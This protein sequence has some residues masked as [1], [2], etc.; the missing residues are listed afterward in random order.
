MGNYVNDLSIY[1][2]MNKNAFINYDSDKLSFYKNKIKSKVVFFERL[3]E[4]E[5]S[6]YES[7]SY[8]YMNEDPKDKRA[9]CM[10]E[11]VSIIS[12][13]M[14]ENMSG[15]KYREISENENK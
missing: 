12:N 11:I 14:F 9:Y 3:T 15:K 7:I 2:L 4:D 6:K 13:D 8:M 5:E 10:D 1:G